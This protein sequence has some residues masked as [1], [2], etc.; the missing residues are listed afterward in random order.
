MAFLENDAVLNEL[1]VRNPPPTRSSSP[2]GPGSGPVDLVFATYASLVDQYDPG[3]HD[4][5][6]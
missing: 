2:C 3:G 5:S 6:A 1:G 4:R